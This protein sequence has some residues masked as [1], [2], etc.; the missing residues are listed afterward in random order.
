[1]ISSISMIKCG[2]VFDNLMIDVQPTNKKL[3]TRA[4]RIISII[5]KVSL[6]KAALLFRKAKKNI[7]AAIVMYF[8]KCALDKAK[9]LLK[10]SNFNLRR[11]IG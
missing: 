7:K 10:K 1:M 8:K 5:C 4:I 6:K 3:V 9:S 2:K 11:V